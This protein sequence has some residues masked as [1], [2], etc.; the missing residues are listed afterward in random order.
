MT[1]LFI[2]RQVVVDNLRSQK[3]KNQ[4]KINERRKRKRE[5]KLKKEQSP[6]VSTKHDNSFTVA[7]RPQHIRWP[8]SMLQSSSLNQKCY[9]FCKA[10]NKVYRNMSTYGA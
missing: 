8:I 1:V 9:S 10:A 2:K 3:E 5:K 6:A 4:I 7:N